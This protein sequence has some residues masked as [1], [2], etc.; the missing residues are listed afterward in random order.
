[1]KH[2]ACA[3]ILVGTLLVAG[4]PAWAQAEAGAVPAGELNLGTVSIGRRVVADGKPLAAGT[5]Q[6]R[7]T[8]QAAQPA[9]KGASEGLER[10]VEFVRGGQVR[11]REVVTIIP[12]SEVKAVAKM[13]PPARG[14]S[15]VEMLKGN[16]YLRIWINRGGNHYLIHLPPA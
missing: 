2:A 1:M 15:R 14:T 13:T 6:V 3:L 10:W 5:Y 16:D 4:A 9:A 12:G 7:L 11:G 8:A